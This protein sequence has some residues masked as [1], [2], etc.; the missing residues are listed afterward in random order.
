MKQ[1]FIHFNKIL[2]IKNS[3]NE[4]FFSFFYDS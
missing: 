3:Y 1:I 2:R 4:L